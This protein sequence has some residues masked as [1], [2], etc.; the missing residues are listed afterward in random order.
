MRQDQSQHHHP[1]AFMSHTTSHAT[2]HGLCDIIAQAL[3]INIVSGTVDIAFPKPS[4]VN[5]TV[6]IILERR[7]T[8]TTITRLNGVTKNILHHTAIVDIIGNPIRGLQSTL[9]A[10]R[11]LGFG[12]FVQDTGPV[13]IE[14]GGTQG[15]V[16]R[17]RRFRKAINGTGIVGFGFGTAPPKGFQFVFAFPT[18]TAKMD[19][20]AHVG[21]NI[22]TRRGTVVVNGNGIFEL[23]G[24]V[25]KGVN[26]AGV[27]GF[28]LGRRFHA[29][30]AIGVRILFVATD[31]VIFRESICE[32]LEEYYLCPEG[33]PAEEGPG[34]SRR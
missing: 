30:D 25:P 3:I 5:I 11:H 13:G 28:A 22:G 19:R 2:T 29:K 31:G 18:V 20:F 10:G 9:I 14:L 24:Q 15:P 23:K 17:W 33:D 27:A 16:R 32:L 4:L 8:R 7:P 6:Q 1:R 12:Q 34:P 21:F 26:A